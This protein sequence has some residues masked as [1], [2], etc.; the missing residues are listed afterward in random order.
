M[1]FWIS[2]NKLLLEIYHLF[3]EMGI[4]PH[5]KLQGFKEE[6]KK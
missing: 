3:L 1:Q 5:G 4:F 2:G 6:L